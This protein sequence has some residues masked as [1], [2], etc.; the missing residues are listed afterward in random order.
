M[1]TWEI[2]YNGTHQ[3]NVMC[4]WDASLIEAIA[5]AG[6]AVRSLKEYGCEVVRV[7]ITADDNGAGRV[8]ILDATEV[9]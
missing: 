1:Y 2:F 9:K 6:R 7:L 3:G 5:D 4:S 8:V